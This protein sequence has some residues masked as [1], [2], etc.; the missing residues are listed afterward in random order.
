MRRNHWSFAIAALAFGTLATVAVATVRAADRKADEFSFAE[1][2]FVHQDYASAAEEFQ[3]FVVAFPDTP[4]AATAYYRIGEA[5]VRLEAF[6]KAAA[7]FAEALRRFPDAEDAPLGRYNLGRCRVHLKQYDQALAAFQAAAAKGKEQV[8]EEALVG[9]GESQIE[10]GKLAEAAATFRDFLAA[11]P[12]SKHGSDVLFSLG[13]TEAR[14]GR[15]EAAAATFQ[16]LLKE[17]PQHPAAGKARLALSDAYTA[18]NRYAEAAAVLDALQ[19]ETVLAEDVLLRQ[20]WNR[21]RSGDKKA[22]ADAFLRFANAFPKSPLRGSALFNAGVSRF[23]LRDFAGAAELFKQVLDTAPAS[24]EAPEA[25]FWFALCQY[26]LEQYPAA[27]ASLEPLLTA[28]V[29]LDAEKEE[30]LRALYPQAQARNGQH[31]PAIAGF[32]AFLAK[33]PKSTQAPRVAYALANSLERTDKLAEAVAVLDELLK[34]QPGPELKEHV[35]FAAAEYRYRLKQPEQA[36]PHLRELAAAGEPSDKVLYRLGWVL[37]DLRQFDESRKVFVRLAAT[38]SPFAP[39]AAYLAG[40]AAEEL[41]DPA[42]AIGSYEKLAAGKGTDEF[43]E[44]AF[45]R[46]G[47]LYDGQKAEDNWRVYRER[48]PRG[49]FA[50]E[51]R[52]KLAENAFAAGGTD[53]AQA[54]YQ[55]L[56][57]DAALKAE[58]RASAEYGLAWC[59]VKRNEADKADQAFARVAAL[60][61]V[62]PALLR[63]SLLQRAE[64]AYRAERFTEAR[65]LFAKLTDAPPQ[66]E[67]AFYMLG[68]SSRKLKDT[69]ASTRYFQEL[70]T[71]FPQTALAP[72]ASLR[73]AENLVIAG[74]PAKACQVLKAAA[75]AQTPAQLGEDFLL[76]YTDCLAAAQLW[77]ELLKTGAACREVFPDSPRRY[78]VTFR[79]GL[80]NQALGLL[81]EAEKEFRDTIARTDTIEA[82][83]AQFN[84]GSLYFSRRD[85]LEAAKNFLRVDMLYDYE[86]LAPRSL[87]Q[88]VECFHRAGEEARAELYLKKMR[89]KFPESEWTKKAARKPPVEGGPPA[90]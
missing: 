18:L 56:V 27:L 90:K 12:K 65:D 22:A 60:S 3:R 71:R 82:A 42:A 9:A 28:P 25:R 79:L 11:F 5:Y 72:D 76:T 84:I 17:Y 75:A 7:A 58:L 68:W 54:H 83:R 1:G 35:L 10:L 37:F 41:K 31:A 46:L 61:G 13:W 51:L 33:Y 86:D 32:R 87:C 78:L 21:F 24:R 4:Q 52:L 34:G 89:D 40:R 47:F 74:D 38:A 19:G 16:A 36:L 14:L 39:E 8:R 81:D 69:A 6:E 53:A 63:D 85:Y 30:T 67:R 15:Q 70:L 49:A 48:F 77:Q 62:A 20:A 26:N 44:R 88:A 23:D 43:T 50:G 29:P 45:Y 80:A 59:H 57:A 66:A 55:A 73:L 2:L 64:I